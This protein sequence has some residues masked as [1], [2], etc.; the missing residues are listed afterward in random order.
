MFLDAGIDNPLVAEDA[1]VSPTPEPGT[2]YLGIP[3]YS[4]NVCSCEHGR[5]SVDS[6]AKAGDN[7]AISVIP[8]TGYLYR[9]LTVL[10]KTTSEFVSVTDNKF[11]MPSSDVSVNVEFY[12][13]YT[14]KFEDPTVIFTDV[15]KGK[16]Y[17]K[18]DGPIAY[19][20]AY[21]IMN[22]TGDGKTF[23]PEGDCTREMFV[24]ILYNSEGKPGAGSSNPFK[25]VKSGKWYYD[26][27]TWAL[28]NDVTKGTSADTF[29]IGGKVTREQLA[30]FLMNYAKKRG[31]DTSARADISKFPDNA[32][33]SGWAKEAISW[34]NA[35][36]IVNGKA[37]NGANYLDPRGN[38]TRAE[39]AQM[40][41]N[42]QKKFGR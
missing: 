34:A 15:A 23:D 32:K 2:Y 9:N 18:T 20:V 8:D 27:V 25:D 14:P 28:A 7:V 11:V 1:R 4:I 42:F 33:V 29:G 26:A 19:V 35:N 39:V 3:M 10:N 24:Q 16:W 31:Y 6:S 13:E 37:K 21:G 12:T 5:I 22:G 30:Q 38:A 41:M 40:I 36:G 17:S